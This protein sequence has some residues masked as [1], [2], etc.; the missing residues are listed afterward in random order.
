MTFSRVLKHTFTK[1]TQLYIGCRI[2]TPIIWVEILVFDLVLFILPLIA[3]AIPKQS[4]RKS[5]I[6]HYRNY[7]DSGSTNLHNVIVIVP[8]NVKQIIGSQRNFEVDMYN[9]VVITVPVDVLALV[10]AWASACV[11]MVEFVSCIYR[12]YP[13]KRALSAMRKHGG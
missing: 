12:G 3:A 9:F 11:M 7:W 8:K 5:S 10:G 4:N 2:F 13:A 1:R 6:S